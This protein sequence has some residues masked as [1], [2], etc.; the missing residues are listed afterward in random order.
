[1]R[2]RPR[3]G[4]APAGTAAKA[5]EEEQRLEEARREVAAAQARLQAVEKRSAA[6]EARAHE[7]LADAKR[8]AVPTK[9]PVAFNVQFLRA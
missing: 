9:R 5:A 3:G 6:V 1:M 2:V 4:S 8:R 7:F